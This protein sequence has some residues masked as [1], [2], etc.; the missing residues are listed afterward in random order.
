[1]WVG[2][3][4]SARSNLGTCAAAVPGSIAGD[5]CSVGKYAGEETV[6][7]AE[8]DEEMPISVSGRKQASGSRGS[9][10]P[11]DS[12]RFLVSSMPNV[13]FVMVLKR[14][15]LSK[16]HAPP[17]SLLEP[18]IT[19]AVGEREHSP[20][21]WGSGSQN[22]RA[23]NLTSPETRCRGFRAMVTLVSLRALRN[24]INTSQSNSV[25]MGLAHSPDGLRRP[26]P[27]IITYLRSR[28]S[29]P[30]LQHATH[31]NQGQ[32][33]ELRTTLSTPVRRVRAVVQGGPMSWVT[34]ARSSIRWQ[35]LAKC[36]SCFHQPKPSS[37]SMLP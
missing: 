37:S 26:R 5:G 34:A 14:C 33:L 15:N 24:R 3:G 2:R 17:R 30:V 1:M 25:V 32:G 11:A 7:V 13:N 36:R 9:S 19:S 12:E 35:G 28:M 23:M 16:R 10:S 21:S 22:Q 18:R 27:T 29:R 31:P 6:L 8:E 20:T 4:A